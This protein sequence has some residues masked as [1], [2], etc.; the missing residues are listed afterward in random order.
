[1]QHLKSNDIWEPTKEEC[2]GG[3]PHAV[4]IV[5]F[6]TT[7][8]G[9]KYWIISN[10]WGEEWANAGYGRIIRGSNLCELEDRGYMTDER[11]D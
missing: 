3:Y 8:E 7:D 2:E 10:S 6:G 4:N 11:G 9:A 1:M 5:G